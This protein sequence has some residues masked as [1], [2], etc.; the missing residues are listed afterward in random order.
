L[1]ALA[2][3]GCVLVYT[4]FY[5]RVILSETYEG[6]LG[7]VKAVAVLVHGLELDVDNDSEDHVFTFHSATRVVD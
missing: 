7:W 6:T 3:L 5:E 2:L 4:S 1:D